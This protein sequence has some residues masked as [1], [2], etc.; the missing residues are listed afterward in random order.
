[1][2]DVY[3]YLACRLYDLH[4]RTAWAYRPAMMHV[5]TCCEDMRSVP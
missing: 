5:T 4:G 1:M 2:R 3:Q